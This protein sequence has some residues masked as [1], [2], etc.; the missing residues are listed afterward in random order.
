M[1]PA[2]GFQ[3]NDGKGVVAWD[4][5]GQHDGNDGKVRAGTQLLD[6]R[7]PQ[8]QE[9][10]AEGRLDHHSPAAVHRFHPLDEG[11][12]EQKQHQQHRQS[13]RQTLE[14][15]ASTKV[16]TVYV[17]KQHQ[18]QKCVEHHGIEAPDGRFLQMEHAF[19][20]IAH[21]HRGEDGDD[22]IQR[23]E[24]TVDQ[25]VYDRLSLYMGIVVGSASFSALSSL[26]LVIA[27]RC[28]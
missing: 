22:S 6:Q 20:A 5:D 3:S 28:G 12:G 17:V 4:H 2:E 18:R 26:G 13:Q 14:A 25:H 24:E 1:L 23:Q 9:V 16:G 8:K 15:G 27:L 19:G 11:P 7:H 10:T 21:R